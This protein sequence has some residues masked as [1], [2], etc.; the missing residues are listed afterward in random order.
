MSSRRWVRRSGNRQENCRIARGY[1][2]H[3]KVAARGLLGGCQGKVTRRR[4]FFP[5][6]GRPFRPRT[7]DKDLVACLARRLLERFVAARLR[8]GCHAVGYTVYRR[9]GCL[10]LRSFMVRVMC[11]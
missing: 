3:A 8:G 11:R 6:R 1:E 4:L 10:V 9:W 7:R 2:P 5:V